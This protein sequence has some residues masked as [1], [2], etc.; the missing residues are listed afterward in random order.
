MRGFGVLFLNLPA[1]EVL[2]VNIKMV[3]KAATVCF[4]HK[5]DFGRDFTGMG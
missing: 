1:L 2:W 4:H 3:C 5:K